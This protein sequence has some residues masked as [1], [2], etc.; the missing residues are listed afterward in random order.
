M[1]PCFSGVETTCF[2][3]NPKLN[4]LGGNSAG[5]DTIQGR[6]PSSPGKHIVYFPPHSEAS[7]IS[8]MAGHVCGKSARL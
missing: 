3:F 7:G 4:S 2:N 6:G 5:P 1:F 8:E